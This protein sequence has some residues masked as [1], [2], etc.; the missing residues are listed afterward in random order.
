MELSII[1]INFNTP[2]ETT[3]CLKTINQYCGGV[4]F[5]IIIIDNAPKIHYEADFRS[6]NQN[7]IY[8]Q[9]DENLGFGKANNIGMSLANGKY[10][11]LLNSDTLLI[12]NSIAKC[13]TFLNLEENKQIGLLGCKLLNE[14]GSFQGSFYPFVKDS[15]WKY[16][17]CNNP[18][19]YKIFNIKTR[20][21]MPNKAIFVGDISGAFM[22]LRKEVFIDTKGFDPDFFL[23]CEETDWCR[24]RII[25][26]VKI[27]YYPEAQIIHLGGKSAP[28]SLM[29]IQSSISL[30]MYWYKKN[31]LSY[32]LYLI[33]AFSNT[34]FFSLQYIFSNSDAKKL[35]ATRIKIFFISL[36]YWLFVIPRHSNKFG[37]RHNPLVYEGARKIFFPSE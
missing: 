23:Y 6:I 19:L 16:F 28:K 2:L 17:I 37:S 8:R 30:A 18:L 9:F 25:N 26:H 10:F 27:L 14:D 21:T 11:L 24:N 35:I 29:Q 12:D 31:L 13:L 33:V 34:I 32:F 5:E 7:I 36:P 15:V 3:N 22:L 1:I 4:D 20:F